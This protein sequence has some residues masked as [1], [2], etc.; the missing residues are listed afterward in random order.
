M[1]K[2]PQNSVAATTD[3]DYA[4]YVDYADYAGKFDTDL[5]QFLA[6]E[7]SEKKVKKKNSHRGHREEREFFGPPTTK[8]EGRQDNR[9]FFGTEFTENREKKWFPASAGMTKSNKRG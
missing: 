9:I 7:N 8:F 6:A 1:R 4:D 3:A 2:K 5:H